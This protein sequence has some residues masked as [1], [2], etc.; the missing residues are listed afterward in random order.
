MLRMLS[1]AKFLNYY[2]SASHPLVCPQPQGYQAAGSLLKAQDDQGPGDKVFGVKT[3][4]LSP[5]LPE[6]FEKLGRE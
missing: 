4:E 5:D 3:T 2:P 1:R 6:E